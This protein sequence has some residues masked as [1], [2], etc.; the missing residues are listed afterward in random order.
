MKRSGKQFSM[1]V[2]VL[3]AI[4]TV[5]VSLFQAQAA[6][7]AGEGTN[8]FAGERGKIHFEKEVRFETILFSHLKEK[9]VNALLEAHPYE[10]VAYDIYSLENDNI[11][12]GLGCTGDLLEPLSENDFLRLVSSVFDAHGIRYSGSYRQDR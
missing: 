5:A 12:Y 10:E 1:P 3:L 8:P 9:V 11:D 7:R 6:F 2:P 4:M